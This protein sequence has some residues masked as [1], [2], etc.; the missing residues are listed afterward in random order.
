MYSAISDAV[1][2]MSAKEIRIQ[3]LGMDAAEGARKLTETS[4]NYVIWDGLG[5]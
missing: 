2:S 5:A 3:L 4:I 1:V